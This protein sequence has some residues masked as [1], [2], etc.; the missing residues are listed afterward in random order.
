[1]DFLENNLC[2]KEDV[3]I[4]LRSS[5]HLT[6]SLLVYWINNNIDTYMVHRIPHFWQT[7]CLSVV[8]SVL[9]IHVWKSEEIDGHID[10]R[11]NLS[12]M[13]CLQSVTDHKA[14]IFK[15]DIVRTFED[16]AFYGKEVVF[17]PSEHRLS[18]RRLWDIRNV[19]KT[20]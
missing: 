11:V 6:S 3:H 18:Q 12:N 15:G 16:C 10:N 17:Y 2:D 8:S 4:I 19:Q 20:S 5:I 14:H 13:R 7:K 9:P 1:M